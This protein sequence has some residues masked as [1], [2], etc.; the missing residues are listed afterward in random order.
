MHFES[1]KSRLVVAFAVLLLLLFVTLMA[2]SIY[3]SAVSDNTV[4]VSTSIAV[5]EP[6]AKEPREVKEVIT[7]SS[8]DLLITYSDGSVQNVGRVVGQDGV[9]QGPTRAQ[10]SSAL[11][12][13][14]TN[15][16]CDSRAPTQEQII[17]ALA[18]YC[19]GGICKGD[20]GVDAP[21]I[22]GDQIAAAVSNFCSD[23]RCKGATGETGATGTAGIPGREPFIACV[24]RTTNDTPTRYVAWKYAD[25]QDTAYRDLYKLPVWAACQNPVEL[26]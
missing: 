25:E 12:E 22:T 19:S 23:G 8:G 16:R 14:C 24:Q 10:I 6:K 20:R 7:N 13:Y 21:P 1:K 26:T 17:A 4:P 2:V 11:L 5:P 18:A 15:G 3:R 9:G